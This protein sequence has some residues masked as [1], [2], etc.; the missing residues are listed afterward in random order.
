MHRRFAARRDV[1]TLD[2]DTASRLLAG[3]LDRGD[4]PPGYGDVA[5]VLAAAAAPARPHEL[6]A[7][8]AALGSFR[9]AV[10]RRPDR[11]R[12]AVAPLAAV[13]TSLL[14]VLGGGAVATATGS[15]PD[16][17]QGVAHNALGAVGVSV[18]AP[19]RVVRPPLFV[20]RPTVTTT[21][22]HRSRPHPA[23]RRPT[24]PASLPPPSLPRPPPRAGPNRVTLAVALCRADGAG[25][26]GTG[27]GRAARAYQ[28]LAGLAGGAPNVPGYCR[29]VLG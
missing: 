16:S 5:A 18:P 1:L 24:R 3:Q 27:V 22:V 19:A 9:A 23:A 21:P 29:S 25:R 10:A 8:D 12:S 7:E 6:A 14:L 20:R 2:G 28:V 4:A 26:L 15:L 13:L 17:A 11:R